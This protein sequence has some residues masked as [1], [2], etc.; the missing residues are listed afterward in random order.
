[1]STAE[2]DYIADGFYASS[3]ADEKKCPD[4][5]VNV[6]LKIEEVTAKVKEG[7]KP[8]RQRRSESVS[9]GG[10][11]PYREGMRYG[12]RKPLRCRDF[13]LRRTLRSLSIPQVHRPPS[14]LRVPEESIA[15]FGG[16]PDNFNYPRYCLIPSCLV[17][18]RTSGWWSLAN[19]SAGAASGVK[20][21]ELVFVTGNPG[22]TGRL[23]TMAQLEY[24]RDVSYPLLHARLA[25]MIKALQA[26]GEQGAENKRVAGH[27]LLSAQNSS[28]AYS[29]FLTGLRDPQL[30]SRKRDEEQK[31]R[32]AVDAD[33]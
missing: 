8:G 7:E 29:G 23:L 4:L 30:M 33:L 11:G 32:A 14:G 9:Q 5:E 25:S 26:Y 2:H 21:G 24:Y 18:M 19:I 28:K 12:H 20:D 6:L 3:F 10:H 15:A 1:M 17:R 22:T 31:L 27:D 13:I 16:D